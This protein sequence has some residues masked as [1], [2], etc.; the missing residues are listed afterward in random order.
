MA[1]HA[2]AGLSFSFNT[3]AFFDSPRAVDP[4]PVVVSD[5]LA[6]TPA[7]TQFEAGA[8]TLDVANL[9]EWFP[10]GGNATAWGIRYRVY[11]RHISG[12]ADNLYEI[13]LRKSGGNPATPTP[14]QLST[15]VIAGTGSQPALCWLGYQV[16]DDYRS[17]DQ[18]WIVFHAPGTN[19]TNCGNAGDQFV[20]VEAS[21]GPT[22]APL[23]LTTAVSGQSVPN[24]LQPVE[25]LYD[26]TGLITGF[27]AIS[28]PPVNAS[29]QPTT[30]V[31]LVQLDARMVVA[32]TLTQTLTGTGVTGGSGD[33]I[34]LG[35]SAGGIWLYKDSSDVWAVDIANNASTRVYT[36][37]S[38]D[39]VHGRAV[40]DGSTAAYVA[41]NN[42][43]TGAYVLQIDLSSKA[44]TVQP[45]DAAATGGIDLAGVTS[46]NVVYLFSDR[47]AIKALRKASLSQTPAVLF[48]ASGT[49]TVDGPLGSPNGTPPVAYLVQDEV[50]F[51]VADLGNG[52]KLAYAAGAGST[53]TTAA[54]IGAGSG[55][56]L[57]TVAGTFATSGAPVNSGALVVTG[58]ALSTS[59]TFSA[60]ALAS[61]G[62]TGT[63]AAP[64]ALG[65]LP[66]TT[67]A[68][69]P[70]DVSTIPMQAG[71]P[72]VLEMTG[73]NAGQ[74]VN[75]VGLFVPGTAG[76][77]KRLTS[78]MQ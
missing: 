45:P 3:V 76:S 50:Y 21:M 52:N 16:F 29:N 32:S 73:S 36:I 13:D 40:F 48:A 2:G 49:L 31:P 34:S 63:L 20:A 15:A 1:G 58:G 4:Y 57:G 11:A 25:A 55:A 72:S 66:T 71:M 33:F 61:Y 64:I 10:A 9:S 24:Q 19:A 14:V 78:N 28:H 12:N 77:F 30:R 7:V 68:L 54:A 75:D 5:P 8:T 43:A 41:I 69:A 59:L 6:S 27:L 39:I 65:T 46:A 56:V 60:G 47:T 42:V 35:V 51:T 53:P 74:P 62:P 18:S 67:L 37:A 22:A 70:L 23:V 26:S 44:H 17:A 38:G